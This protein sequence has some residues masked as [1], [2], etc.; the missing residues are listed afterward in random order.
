MERFPPA[1]SGAEGSQHALPC[2]CCRI[3]LCR[4]EPVAGMVSLWLSV[5]VRHGFVLP[6][7]GGVCAWAL[8]RFAAFLVV[9]V[10]NFF[11]DLHA[12]E[13]IEVATL[14]TS[15]GCFPQAQGR[16]I[17]ICLPLSSRALM[18]LL[19]RPSSWLLLKKFLGLAFVGHLTEPI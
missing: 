3:P 1:A 7:W 9:L 6:D 13:G 16:R 4:L 11:S 5:S 10:K 15:G 19:S 12:S 8:A 17:G 14:R 18:I 2:G